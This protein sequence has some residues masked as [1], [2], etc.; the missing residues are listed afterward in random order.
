MN[1]AEFAFNLANRALECRNIPKIADP[2]SRQMGTATLEFFH[3]FMRP[4]TCYV[5]K[6]HPGTLKCKLL[7]HRGA[8]SSGT[9]S[10]QDMRA[11]KARILS[12]TPRPNHSEVSLDF[13]EQL[14][15]LCPL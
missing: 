3:Q 1:R 15:T 14:T 11:F 2:E 5:N 13:S 8:Y 6:R 9:T 4:G 12:K 7:D 10:D